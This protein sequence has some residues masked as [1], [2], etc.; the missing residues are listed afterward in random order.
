MP[1]MGDKAD[2]VL[3]LDKLHLFDAVTERRLAA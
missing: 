2:L 1:E 3:E